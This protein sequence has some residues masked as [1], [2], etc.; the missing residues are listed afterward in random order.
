MEAQ[1][2]LAAKQYLR[3]SLLFV[4]GVISPAEYE[5]VQMTFLQSRYTLENGYIMLENML[6]QIGDLETDLLDMKLQQTERENVLLQNCRT[7]TEQLMNAV[8]EWELSYC[9][10]SPVEGK[11]SFTKYWHENQFIQMGE[12]VFA[13]VPAK[14][15]ELIGKAVL[16]LQRSGKVKTGRRVI[17]RFANFPDQEFGI[18]NGIVKSVSLVPAENNYLIEIAL[19]DGLKTNYRKTLP[20]S[21]EMKATAEI[22]VEELTLLE[23]FFMPLKRILKEGF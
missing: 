14:E 20:V 13:V 19:P 15:D 7:S 22:V 5:T 18:V 2:Q 11:V 10:S 17:I 23:R 9:L 16:P 1:H 21:Y 4:R 12:N 6:I 3:D 8:Q